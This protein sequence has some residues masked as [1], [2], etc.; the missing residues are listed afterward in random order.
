MV[1]A[2]PRVVVEVI[3]ERESR[4]PKQWQRNLVCGGGG[5]RETLVC[6][7][8]SGKPCCL[9]FKPIEAGEEEAI[10]GGEERVGE[11]RE[12]GGRRRDLPCLGFLF[13]VA[14][15]PPGDFALST[16]VQN[17]YDECF[18]HPCLNASSAVQHE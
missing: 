18:I 16:V 15:F 8:G 1:K 5:G 3:Y 4:K 2:N 11:E 9:Y 12:G 13:L 10:R 7:G 6:G 14:L 17:C